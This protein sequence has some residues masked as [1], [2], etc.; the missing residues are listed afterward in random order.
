MA[1]Q[2]FGSYLSERTQRVSIDT[3]SS[4]HKSLLYGVPQGSVLGPIIFCVYTLPL[5]RIIQSHGIAYHIYADDTQFLQPFNISDPSPA[6]HKLE[7]CISDIRK[8]MIENQLKI[9]DDKTELI[10]ITSK[11]KKQCASDCS[12]QIGHCTVTPS[13]SAR[14]LGVIFVSIMSMDAHISQTCRSIHGHLRGIGSIR[15]L[16]STEA[17]EQL[18]HALISSRLDYCNVLLCGLPDLKLQRLQRSQNCAARIVSRC[19]KRD[20]ITPILCGLHWLPIRQR[21]IF[22][23]LLITFKTINGNSPKYLQHLISLYQPTR[24]LR[25]ADQ[26]LLTVPPTRLKSCGERSF[27]Y[28]AAMAWNTLPL[29]IRTSPSVQTFKSSL[30]T[31]LFKQA[32]N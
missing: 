5:G 17:T 25:S 13:P 4:E 23:L 22:K 1:L 26:F 32:F 30:K 9:N 21:I 14:N 31:H 3:V 20:H 28:A 6:L 19:R 15:H 12:I 10:R 29:S 11:P 16:L 24:T 7:H 2:W 8:W 18:V 27:P